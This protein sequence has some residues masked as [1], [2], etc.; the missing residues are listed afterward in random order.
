MGVLLGPAGSCWV[1]GPY[2]DL[3]HRQVQEGVLVADADQTFGAF[4]AHTGSQAA[5]ELDHGQ[6]A[7]AGAHVGRKPTSFD[8]LVRLNLGRGTVTFP[9]E[10]AG[11]GCDLKPGDFYSEI[12]LPSLPLLPDFTL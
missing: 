7:E 11:L 12:R 3:L 2:L 5:V 4:A 1:L 10:G 9:E 6:L 8:L